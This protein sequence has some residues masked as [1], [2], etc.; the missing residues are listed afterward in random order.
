[1]SAKTIVRRAPKA[2]AAIK[3]AKRA[4]YGIAAKDWRELKAAD[5]MQTNVIT[6]TE[7][8]PLSEVETLLSENRITGMPVTDEAGELVGV[9]SVT[10][11]IERY[12][13]DSDARPRR[14]R[15][16]YDVT[17]YG[18][19][20]EDLETFEVPKESEETAG[21]LMTAEVLTVKAETP[22][23]L[24]AKEMVKHKVHRLLVSE[25]RKTVGIISTMDLLRAASK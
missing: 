20:E 5:I 17:T 7:D 8:A 3:P 22:L 4:N 6:V 21:S 11:L 13:E 1:M 12:T 10:D 25:G 14:G 18:L 23:R 9:I 15:G 2:K 24:V 19:E 16:F